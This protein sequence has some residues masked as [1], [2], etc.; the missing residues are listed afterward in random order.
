M[1]QDQL[2]LESSKTSAKILSVVFLFCSTNLFVS[3]I[4]TI[5]T[6]PGYIPEEIEWDMPCESEDHISEPEEE[7]K[8]NTSLGNDQQRDSNISDMLKEHNSRIDNKGKKTPK[9]E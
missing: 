5:T 1:W 8:S 3:I 9:Q 4:M 7:R 6:S 2:E